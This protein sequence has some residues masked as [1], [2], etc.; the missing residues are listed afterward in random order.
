MFG[1]TRRKDSNLS[2]GLGNAKLS[3]AIATFS[4]PAGWTCPFA[5]ECLSKANRLTGRIVDGQHCRFRCF[6]ASQECFQPSVRIARWRNFELIRQ[7]RTVEKMAN[8]IQKSIPYGIT[9]VRTHV[10]GD[11]FSERYFLAWLNVALN[12]PMVTFYGYTKAL[13]HLVKYKKWIPGNFRFTASKGGTCDNLIGKHRLRFAEVVFSPEEARRKG[14]EIDHD[15]SHAFGGDKSFALLLHGTQPVGSEASK[16]WASLQREGMGGYGDSDI[17][18]KV[19][20]ERSVT[21][22]VDLKD[23]EIYL[24]QVAKGFKFVPKSSGF[25]HN[26]VK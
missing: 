12:N 7:A 14:F 26:I 13:P 8:L 18:R 3:K 17:S 6:A 24:P 9:M 2:F 11:F 19:V 10:S 21:V 15:D 16:A 1:R 25:R 20:F 23:N 4:L 22:H 5:K